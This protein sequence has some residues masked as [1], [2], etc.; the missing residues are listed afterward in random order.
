MSA[1]DDIRKLL[2]DVVPP[3][4]EVRIAALEKTGLRID[5][6]GK[7]TDVGFEKTDA[8]IDAME[9]KTD[10]RFDHLEQKIDMTRIHLGE[11]IDL[12]IKMVLA[13]MRASK[14][15]LEGTMLQLKQSIELERR[16]AKME[17]ERAA[18]SASPSAER[19]A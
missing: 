5:S 18:E 17:S 10:L 4:L 11:T 3:A 12:S 7:K 14:A 15:S 1:V 8:R 16:V 13:E 9:K 19:I 6:L 2:Q